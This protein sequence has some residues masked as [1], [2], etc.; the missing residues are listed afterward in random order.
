MD[1]PRYKTYASGRK[2]KLCS[3][4]D[5]TCTSEAKTEGKCIGCKTGNN[6]KVF[7]NRREGEVFAVNK[8]NSIVRYRRIG[9]QSRK[10]CIGD[11]NT[12]PALR[13]VDKLCRGHISGFKKYGTEGLVKGDVIERNGELRLYD[14]I[15]LRQFCDFPECKQI[16]VKDGKCKSHSESWRC[17]FT[18]YACE[19]IRNFGDY[20]TLHRDNVQ[21]IKERSIGETKVAGVLTDMGLKFQCNPPVKCSGKILYPDFLLTEHNVVIE[22]DGVQHFQAVE[23]WGGEEGLKGRQQNDLTKEHWC[24]ENKILLLRISYADMNRVEELIKTFMDIVPTLD[25]ES[26]SLLWSSDHLCFENKYDH[27]NVPQLCDE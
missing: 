3:G 5:N 18:G 22:F 27:V 25:R 9:G 24:L 23:R 19:C 11:D 2:V 14:G 7:D 6:K 13:E 4:L 15:Q 10:L 20:C 12:C 8:P 26:D 16:T 21:R 17:K 1:A